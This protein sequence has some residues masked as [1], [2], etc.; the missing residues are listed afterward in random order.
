MHRD[1]KRIIAI[2]L[3][4]VTLIVTSIFSSQFFEILDA[5][6]VMVVQSP[7]SGELTFHTTP[8][9]KWQ[10][11][12]NVTK[13]QRR[14]QYWFVDQK[15]APKGTTPNFGAI[16]TTFNDG[17]KAFVGGSMSWEMPTDEIHLRDIHMKYGSHEAV[18]QQLILPVLQKSIGMTGPL[19]SSTESYASRKNELLGFIDDQF[20]RGVYRTISRDERQAD[21]LT[22]VQKTVRVVEIQ[23]DSK[24]LQYLREE[25]SPIEQLGISVFN[26][27]PSLIEYDPAVE[28][29]IKQQQASTMAVQL[30]IADAKKAEQEVATTN[31]RGAADAAKA[32]WAQKVLMATAVTEAQQKKEVALTEAAQKLEVAQLAVQEAEQKKLADIL[33]GEGE[34]MRKQLVMNADGALADKLQAWTQVNT[35]YA[36]AIGNYTGNWVPSVSFAGPTGSTTA[37]GTFSADSLVSLLT[38]KTAKDLAFDMAIPATAGKLPDIKRPEMS[39]YKY[40]PKEF[41]PTNLVTPQAGKESLPKAVPVATPAASATK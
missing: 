32:E 22:G 25:T 16:R 17:G 12:G 4:V 7:F 14:A 31:A 8:G 39:N 11:F 36:Q 41:T 30:A 23:K 40:V 38:A 1:T 20:R 27:T 5:K 2:I 26:L 24:T 35:A 28:E 18:E 10:G 21:P 13:Y 15:D 3:G 34:A 33:M 29:Q 37:G 19:M 9:T 6:E